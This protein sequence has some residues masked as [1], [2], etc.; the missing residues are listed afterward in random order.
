VRLHDDHDHGADDHGADD[1]GADNDGADDEHRANDDGADDDEHRADHDRASVDNA[2]DERGSDHQRADDATERRGF[3]NTRRKGGRS[4]AGDPRSFARA[5]P[6][7]R[8]YSGADYRRRLDVRGCRRGG[9]ARRAA[10][11]GRTLIG[12]S[13]LRR[14]PATP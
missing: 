7:D 9:G 8:N 11:L 2:V 3:V 4:A 6:R 10:S 14:R 5:A 12:V 13:R 1:H